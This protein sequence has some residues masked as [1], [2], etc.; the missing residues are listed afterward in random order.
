MKYLTFSLALSAFIMSLFNTWMIHEVLG[1]FEKATD[2][3]G[4]II[5]LL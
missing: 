4:L 3:I 2:I 1:L 5:D